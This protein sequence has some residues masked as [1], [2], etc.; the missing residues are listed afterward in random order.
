MS[1]TNA[2]NDPVLSH[3]REL[4]LI[5][6]FGSLLSWDM[7]TY[8]PPGAAEFR[9]AQM[10]TAAALVHARETD[11]TFTQKALALPATSPHAHPLKRRLVNALC[12]DATWVSKMVSAQVKCQDIWKKAR[13]ERNF[14][15]VLP[16]L[17]ELI[18]LQRDWAERY[19]AHPSANP[20]LRSRTLYD[21]CLNYF[22]PGFP[23]DELA[24]LLT[25]L[26]DSLKTRIPNYVATSKSQPRGD[27]ASL[28][29][30]IPEQE[31]F[32]KKVAAALGFDFAHGRLDRS[33]HPFCGGSPQDTRITVRYDAND[34]TN[35]LSSLVHETGHALYEQGLPKEWSLTPAGTAASFGIHESQSRFME[36]QIGRSHAFS[37]WIASLTGRDATAI[38]AK[39]N[40][41]KPSLIRVDAD[42]ATYNLHIVLRSEIE[43]ELIN[44][45][46]APK[47]IPERWNAAYEKYLGIRPPHDGDGC[48]QDIHWF[49]GAFGYF[50][51]YTL[52][53]LIAAQLFDALK[54]ERSG[55]EAEVKKGDFTGIVGFLRNRVHK[56]GGQHDSPG[57]L[58]L[59]LNG[60]PLGVESFLAYLDGKYATR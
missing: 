31:E 42:E 33:T 40:D 50:P 3:Y 39:L 14:A 55:W 20:A 16:A 6:S 52:G 15:M 17:T 53:N 30:P 59:A 9:G 28:A 1:A 12:V 58:K 4:A 45:S 2:S 34:L 44:G 38:Y 10:S 37:E 35:A 46:L 11:A 19:R 25:K 27:V 29:M 7:E 18:E 23:S 48:L 13:K 47:D 21:V 8:M 43:R 41:V 26:G 49:G 57:T 5:E 54:K 51:T 56:L 36:N 60:Q 24:Q 32:L 22:E